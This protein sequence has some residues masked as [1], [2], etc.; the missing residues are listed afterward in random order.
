METT[1]TAEKG[2][3]FAPENFAADM[4]MLATEQG[5]T[6]TPEGIVADTPT[7]TPAP[8]VQP[9][10]LATETPA[11]TPEPAKVEVK[12]VVVPDKF[13]APDG[14]LDMAKVEKSTMS[15]DQAL[16]KYLEKEKELKRKIN[17][18][19]ASENA[20]LN[21]ANTPNPILSQSVLNAN[22]PFH[23]QLEQDVQA[24]GLGKTLEKL[25]TASQES[26]LEQARKEIT[27]IKQGYDQS[28]TKN[29]IEAI[30]KSDPWV[31]T[32][33]GVNTLNRILTE[34]PYLM[35]AEDPYKAAYI[36][37]Q[38]ILGVNARIAGTN[39]QVLT[40]N[41]TA[42]ASAPV[43]TARAADSSTASPETVFD[44]L[45]NA[46]KSEFIKRL[47]TAEQEKWFIRSGF[48]AFSKRA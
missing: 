27:P 14:T 39:T 46:Q 2:L 35:N 31:Y 17:E 6:I 47:P 5:K 24:I 4:Q 30:G 13:K 7:Q 26:A 9:E 21:P 1:Q 12:P 45:T 36:A 16:A 32:E 3:S 41:P 22:V 19:K 48:P 38:G 44:K 37:Y 15:A 25:F 8:A 43:P 28:V 40:P 18:V 23:Q 20:Y 29:Q 11:V 33:D 10:V 34:Q 42:R